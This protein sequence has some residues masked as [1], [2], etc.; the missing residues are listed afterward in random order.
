MTP[1]DSIILSYGDMERD[2]VQSSQ[3]CPRCLGG[4]DKESSL[5]VGMTGDGFLWWRCHRASCGFRGGWRA[6]GSVSKAGAASARVRTAHQFTSLP[7]P[8]DVALM[9][10]ERLHVPVETFSE[11]GWSY[12]PAYAGR[13]R[14]VVI[15]I[16][17]PS[18]T[19]RGFIFRSYWGDTPKAM[20]EILPD[21]GESIAWFRASRY[22]TTVVVVED[23][24]S[25]HR[26]MCSGVDAVA[27]LGTTINEARASEM[28]QAGY[29]KAIVSLDND[30]TDQAIR[31]V[32]GLTR[33]SGFFNVKPLDKEDVKDMDD[34]N[35]DKFVSEVRAMN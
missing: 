5:S 28:V 21:T 8:E 24:P 18:G 33:F 20:N 32:M 22:G 35:F 25:A 23:A 11:T 29:K 26:L 6:D 7:L 3:E 34:A 30:A 27:L 15:P 13:G 2:T 10:A 14:R 31:Q 19:R 1:R 12:T 16:R 17:D 9:L 4:Q